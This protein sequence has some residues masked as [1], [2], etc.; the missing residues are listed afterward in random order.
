MSNKLNIVISERCHIFT[1]VYKIIDSKQVTAGYEN[2]HDWLFP[3]CFATGYPR[4]RTFYLLV[5]SPPE[6]KI[7]KQ[8]DLMKFVLNTKF[9]LG[10]RSLRWT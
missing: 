9:L 1:S 4:Y 6:V 3:Y 7:S 8:Q 2:D 5:Q 10:Q